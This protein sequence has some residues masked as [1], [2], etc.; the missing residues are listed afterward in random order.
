MNSATAVRPF[1]N[2]GEYEGMVDYFLGGN[3]EFLTGMGVD[4]AKLPT[5]AEWLRA[6]L[7]D[8]ERPD[9]ETQRFFVA[10]LFEGRI[11]GHSSI[12]HIAT[13]ET[14]HCH[15]HLW[16]PGL[17]KSGMGSAFLS[18]SIDI[19]F[20]RFALKSLAS[21]PYAENPAPNRALPKLGFR[22]VRRY[23][24]VP[25]G[26]AFE[27]DVNRYEITRDEWITL[28]PRDASEPGQRR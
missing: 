20:E 6:A 8:H 27:Q 9:A 3:E 12:S 13:G 1:A 17:R 22:F 15:L 7:A 14:A 26:M 10:W 5:R 4:L 25:T 2:E 21:E 19:Y 23:R 24:T 18:G 28:R 16:K 11:V